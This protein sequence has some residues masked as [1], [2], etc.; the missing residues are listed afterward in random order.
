MFD[1]AERDMHIPKILHRI[2]L[3]GTSV[4]D[5][6]RRYWDEWS[7]LHPGWQMNTWT[8][9]NIW[10]L[11][12]QDQFDRAAAPAQ[13]ADILRLEVLSRFGGVY[14]DTDFQPLRPLDDLMATT[15]CFLARE[16]DQWIAIGIMGAQPG[17]GFIDHLIDALPGSFENGG[18][19][20][21]QTGP[22]FV[23]RG[24]WEWSALGHATPTIYP[25]ELFY[26]YHFS[27]PED[28]DGP[29]PHAYA[30]HHW[31]GSWVS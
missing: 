13:R 21:E 8:D 9:R 25:P 14:V 12:N 17:H 24:F 11:R 20:T 18:S 1:S 15:E 28:R 31:A 5:T 7:R 16:D 29:F 6:S 22:R 30:V 23:T 10:P 2:W 4:P 3:G 19:I 26:P 27:R